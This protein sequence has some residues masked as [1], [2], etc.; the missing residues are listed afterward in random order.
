MTNAQLLV[1][2][3][4][5]LS[6]YTVATATSALGGLQFAGKVFDL[7][8]RLR[9]SNVSPAKRVAAL[10]LSA[11][12]SALEIEQMILPTMER[13]GWIRINR[14]KEG[15]I[16]SVEDIVPPLIDLELSADRVL[17]VTN[18]DGTQGA[19]LK[20]LEDTTRFPLEKE[21]ALEGVSQYG[22]EAA[23]DALRYLVEVNLVRVVEA[24]DGRSAVFNP[25][26][27]SEDAL[28]VTAALRVEDA[29]VRKEVGAL[30]EEVAASPGMPE[31][32]VSST[33]KK[34]INFAVSHGLIHRS[35]V[36]TSEGKERAFLFTPHLAKDAFGEP[37][38]DLS[39]HVRQLVGSMVYAATFARYTLDDPA[40]F[41]RRLIERGRAGNASPI[42]SDYPM[43]ETAGIVKVVPGQTTGR[44][45][46]ELQQSDIAES[47][48]EV[49]QT[50]DS[51]SG[52]NSTQ[53]SGLF[54][55][56]EYR[57]VEGE[58]ARLA[59]AVPTDDKDMTR[60]IAAL[61][62]ATRQAR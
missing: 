55:Q 13:L 27:W 8:F 46:L 24:D 52:G 43:L 58:R 28:A 30:I 29:N 7:A 62:S 16:N 51:T 19:A 11:H 35:V 39:G 10:G 18:I 48:L 40:L 42:G 37:R 31:T 9:G 57:H 32:Q 17:A 4:R 38:K 23:E 45:A 6:N 25:N 5:H 36:I 22:D 21:A 56:K 1:G 2:L 20:L 49:L 15:R 50:R 60:L 12:I 44:F 53:A 26:I 54:G 14:D 3:H 41:V 47:A 33:Q 61:R 59:A 34:W